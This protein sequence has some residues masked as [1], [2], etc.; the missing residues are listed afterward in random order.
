MKGYFKMDQNRVAKFYKVSFEQYVT[1]LFRLFPNELTESQETIDKL[2][3]QYNKLELPTRATVGSAGYDFHSPISFSLEPGEVIT[4]PTG[5]RCFIQGGYVLTVVPRSSL[6]FNYQVSL[7]NNLG[8]ID[9]DYFN[10][11]NEGHIMAKFVN[12]GTETL[13][14]EEGDRLVQGIFLPFGITFDDDV[15]EERTGGIGSTNK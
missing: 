15:T 8:V 11:K 3:D 4:I 2:V 14:V 9:A 5:I 13:T 10:A 6:G 7:V 1:D 12:N